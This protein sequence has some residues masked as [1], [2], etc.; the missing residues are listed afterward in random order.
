MGPGHIAGLPSNHAAFLD[1]CVLTDRVE[2]DD[3][4]EGRV[5]AT[6]SVGETDLGGHMVS[7]G[8]ARDWPRYSNGAYAGEE[9]SARGA[10]R[11]LWGMS[12]PADLWGDRDYSR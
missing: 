12:C 3:E 2:I 10:R 7:Q 5:T 6:C 9:L 11:G 4:Y 8:W 1:S